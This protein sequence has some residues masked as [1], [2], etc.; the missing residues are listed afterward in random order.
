MDKL[1]KTAF[2][3]IY[4]LGLVFLIVLQERWGKKD[5]VPRPAIAEASR[6]CQYLECILREKNL[7]LGALDKSWKQIGTKR[8]F[9]D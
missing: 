8:L 9:P 3:L 5:S 6:K 2:L 7:V 4:T 1:F